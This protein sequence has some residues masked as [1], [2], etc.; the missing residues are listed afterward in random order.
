[1]SLRLR[2]LA[3]PLA[4]ALLLPAAACSTG[5]ASAA[6]TDPLAVVTG[7]PVP[8][9][10]PAAATL[11][12]GAP[13]VGATLVPGPFS[14]RFTLDGLTLADGAVTARLTVTSDVSDLLDLEVR[15]D[16]YDAAGHLLASGRQSDATADTERFHTSEGVRGL[17]LRIA[18]PAGAVAALVSVPVLVNE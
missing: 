18:A 15:A 3:A 2:A 6:R 11:P 16:F 4:V 13:R 8:T 17:P 12:A 9:E 14:D 1:M 7:V 5:A 10:S